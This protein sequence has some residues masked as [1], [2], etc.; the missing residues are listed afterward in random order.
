M[1]TLVLAA[2]LLGFAPG[3]TFP[4]SFENP[5]DNPK[6]VKPE[7]R[8]EAASQTS[9]ATRWDNLKQLRAGDKI[10]VVDA[11]FEKI[12]GQFLRVA[13]D[14]FSLRVDHQEVVIRR[15]EV[16]MV[17]IRHSKAEL[18]LGLMLVGAIWGATAALEAHGSHCEPDYR[19]RDSEPPCEPG[20]RHRNSKP[21]SGKDVAISAGVGAAGMAIASTLL[22]PLDEAIYVH[23][24][25]K[26][27]EIAPKKTG[28]APGTEN[29][30]KPEGGNVFVPLRARD[31]KELAENKSVDGT[32]YPP[33]AEANRQ[34]REDSRQAILAAKT[35]C[36]VGVLGEFA[37]EGP[38]NKSEW[39]VADSAR[40][41]LKFDAAPARAKKQVEK[42]IRKWG[43]FSLVED[44]AQADLVL[45]IT[46]GTKEITYQVTSEGAEGRQESEV[47]S[48]RRLVD[49]LRV[50]KA[51]EFSKA[52][53]TPLWDS[54]EIEFGKNN[55]ALKF[56]ATTAAIKFRKFVEAL[57]K[58][59]KE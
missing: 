15:N 25:D 5:Q 6:G 16:T 31:R 59:R 4:Q 49:G 23:I 3:L 40:G 34:A 35:V 27:Y 9:S 54:G 44:P 11:K 21:P 30:G 45:V 36:V 18:I 51:K 52:D 12:K 43:Q 10:R 19:H 2:V 47:V 20:Y 26:S 56:P 8:S 1:R 29:A 22:D 24:P 53:T 58:V 28:Q 17:S 39:R 41:F 42:V 38:L 57:E 55:M 48:E 14:S 37:A 33:A 32:R 50:F 46:E 7:R 13:E